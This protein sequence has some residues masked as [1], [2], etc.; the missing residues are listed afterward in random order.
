MTECRGLKHTKVCQS[1][2]FFTNGIF[3]LIILCLIW[4]LTHPDLLCSSGNTNAMIRSG[5]I[6][7]SCPNIA[8]LKLQVVTHETNVHAI[9]D[10][11]HVTRYFV[12]ESRRALWKVVEE[13]C[14]A[15]RILITGSMGRWW[16]PF[17]NRNGQLT[18]NCL[19][20]F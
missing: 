7:M 14:T 5:K 20:T 16:N 18:K 10:L 4:W 8:P 17:F 15:N 6:D 2:I 9:I 3:V 12:K 13:T 19:Q 11:S 1:S